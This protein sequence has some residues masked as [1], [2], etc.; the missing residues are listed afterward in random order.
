ML[1]HSFGGYLAVLYNQK[2]PGHIKRLIL[3]SP[4]GTSF[5][6]K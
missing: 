6:T 3:L 2:Y 5:K 4:V 1:G